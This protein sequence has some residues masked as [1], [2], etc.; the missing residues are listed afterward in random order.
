MLAELEKNR[1]AASGVDERASGGGLEPGGTTGDSEC[2]TALYGVEVRTV[3][4]GELELVSEWRADGRVKQGGG[5]GLLAGLLQFE[6]LVRSQV[7]VG[8]QGSVDR[9]RE[10]GVELV[11]H[12][13]APL[14]GEVDNVRGR[15]RGSGG[16]RRSGRRGL[17]SVRRARSV[18]ATTRVD[19][20]SRRS[21][22][23]SS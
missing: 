3:G 19:R 4:E 20:Q 11:V 23:G 2:E 12:H 14:P 8:V 21:S 16:R 5:V 7:G 1:A 10:E 13:P 15:L 6:A 18:D 17:L 22:S 9:V